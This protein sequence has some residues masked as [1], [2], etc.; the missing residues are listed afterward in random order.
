MKNS[1]SKLMKKSMAC[2]L[3]A[4]V[5]VSF[6]V[7]TEN[8][9][10][11][12]SKAKTPKKVSGLKATVNEKKVITLRWKKAKNAK[13]YQV[14]VAT[15]KKFKKKKT[16]KKRTFVLKGKPGKVYKFKVRGISKKKIGKFSKVYKVKVPDTKV[17]YGVQRANEFTGIYKSALCYDIKVK[18]TLDKNNRIIKVEDG[19]SKPQGVSDVAE[20][21]TFKKSKG[22]DVYKG[23]TLN[24]VKALEMHS[25]EKDYPAE[26]KD[27]VK[28]ALAT[29][30]SIRLAVINAIEGLGYEPKSVIVARG[31]MKGRPNKAA[32][33]ASLSY[34][35]RLKVII[36]KKTKK[37]VK[38]ED[39]GTE[40]T[41]NIYWY[42]RWWALGGDKAYIGKTLKEVKN[43]NMY[44]GKEPMVSK[45]P[46]PDAIAGATYTS[47]LAKCAVEQ[48]MEKSNAFKK[49]TLKVIGITNGTNGAKI[50]FDNKLPKKYKVQLE[51]LY[52]G[53]F[54]GEKKV[55]GA[56]LSKDGKTLTVGKSLEPGYYSVN[57]K[58]KGGKYPAFNEKYT[59]ADEYSQPYF[60]IKSDDSKVTWKENK[61]ST[62]GNTVE[63]LVDNIKSIKVRNGMRVMSF[64]APTRDE[65][66]DINSEFY[67]GIK[68]NNLFNK[69]GSL[70]FNFKDP[71]TGKSVIDEKGRYDVMVEFYGNAE[72]LTIK[73][74]SET[75]VKY[76]IQK[77]NANTGVPDSALPYDFKVKVTLEVATG[78][79]LKVEN[80]GT[81]PKSNPKN[82]TAEQD[83]VY[84]KKY[85]DEGGL[86]KYRFKTL[87]EVKAMEMQDPKYHYDTGH[88]GVDAITGA[89]ASSISARLAVINALESK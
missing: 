51:G 14:F 10:F 38:L 24:S 19:G 2:L 30:I 63:N 33:G 44:S 43:L 25:W 29:S 81:D 1:L 72:R 7:A 85:F 27:A 21:K 11:A 71:K 23:K 83:A 31:N 12:T 34:D 26:G 8:T 67:K 5:C 6:I 68:D 36:D 20:F 46:G 59:K 52:Q 82:D 89:T 60:V 65:N 79:I 41:G 62:T 78:R 70:N 16:T 9:S 53:T 86:R 84:L 35:T 77:A 87:E 88:P 17:R 56:K 48:A 80:D 75:V 18:V 54:N 49:D 74:N 66:L 58:D 39:D 47:V 4:I 42:Q 73:L 32:N 76:G 37:I 45:H 28:G 57:I 3:S 15:K 55:A 69:D 64:I 22:Y 61:L 40:P 13:K 50:Y